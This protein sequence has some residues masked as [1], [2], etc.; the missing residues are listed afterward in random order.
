LLAGCGGS[1]GAPGAGST[2]P[3]T[4]PSP[5]S[6]P[7]PRTHES[8]TSYPGWIQASIP[9]GTF[10][11]SP[12]TVIN[13][14]G[15]WPTK[16]G[17]IAVG[18]M[19]SFSYIPPAVASA[20]RAGKTIIMAVGEQGLGPNF[21]SAASAP[22][23]AQLVRSIVSYVSKYNF[24]GVDVDW[25]EEVPQNA[26]NYV[27][28][29]KDLRAA[30]DQAFPGRHM[31]L[32]AD[33]DLGQNPPGIVA[34]IAASVDTLNLETF[35]SN[36]VSDVTAYTGAGI[37]AGKLLLGVGVAPGYYDTTES[38]VAAKVRYAEDHGLKGTILW[39]PGN[40]HTYRTD[41]RL[42]PLRQMIKNSP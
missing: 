13:D 35:Q 15:L 42:I 4:G 5:G 27:A 31:Y 7:S 9:P 37:P 39:Q 22:Y 36:G 1:R 11:Y 30:L 29:V 12:W 38:S 8:F 19:G 32:S 34:Q 41:P 18:D 26:A 16:T 20:H 21:A 23:R 24:D 33:V 2:A 25:E 28:L 40:L 10:D 14:F 3:G 6:A 17:G